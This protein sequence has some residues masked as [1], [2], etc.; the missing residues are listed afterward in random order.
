MKPVPLLNFLPIKDAMREQTN[1]AL[2]ITVA[3][4]NNYRLEVD[5]FKKHP[6]C[7]RMMRWHDNDIDSW[8]HMSQFVEHLRQYCDIM[9]TLLDEHHNAKLMATGKVC[10]KS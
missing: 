2:D 5:A 1:L 9:D 8:A 4:A 10:D 6:A 7:D 3:L